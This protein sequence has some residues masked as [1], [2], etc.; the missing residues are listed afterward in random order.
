MKNS[1]DNKQILSDGKFYE[2]VVFERSEFT[3]KIL[4]N[5]EFYQCEFASSDFM[6]TS[7][8][9]CRFEKCVFKNSDFSLARIK[10]CFFIT[11]KFTDCKLIGIDWT[12]AREPFRADFSGCRLDNSVFYKLDLRMAKITECSLISADFESANLSKAKLNGCDMSGCKFINTNL[13]GADFRDAI[14][15]AVNPQANNIRSARFSLP[16]AITLLNYLDITI[17]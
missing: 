14:N 12:I 2:D 6:K 15:Y 7:F 9:K 1:S 3:G 10:D 8:E 11:C 17:E 4:K 16:E 13:S 5:A